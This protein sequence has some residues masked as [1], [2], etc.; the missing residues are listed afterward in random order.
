MA[1]DAIENLMSEIEVL[2]LIQ[3]ADTLNVMFK[4]SKLFPFA[5]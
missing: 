2:D 4:R 5:D 3:K 1:E